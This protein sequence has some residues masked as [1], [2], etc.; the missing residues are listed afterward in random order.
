MP[1]AMNDGSFNFAI[2]LGATCAKMACCHSGTVEIV[3]NRE[4]AN[5]TPCA[6]WL[7]P[8]ENLVVGRVAKEALSTDASNVKLSFISDL[9]SDAEYEFPRSARRMKSEEL[10]AELLKS[11]RL[12]AEQFAGREI[13]SVVITVPPNAGVAACE[14]TKRAASNAGFTNCV[15]LQEPVAAAIGHGA[16]AE[17]PNRSL[18]IYDFG[19]TRFDASI[20]RIRDGAFQVAAHR[21][22]RFLGGADL[23]RAVVK[24]NF[25]PA[26]QAAH[27]AMDIS[28][29][30]PKAH[31]VFVKLQAEAEAAKIR[32]DQATETSVSISHLGEDNRGASF[33]FR[34]D[35]TCAHLEILAAPFVERSIEVC[36]EVLAEAH[37][38]VSE[39]SSMI[40]V[41]GMAAMPFV[42]QK[43]Q[44]SFGAVANQLPSLVDPATAVARGAAIFGASQIVLNESHAF[45]KLTEFKQLLTCPSDD[46]TRKV[47]PHESLE[48][49][50]EHSQTSRAESFPEDDWEMI[51][52]A[53][54]PDSPARSTALNKLIS[55]YYP[56]VIRCLKSEKHSPEE[57][58]D[59]AQGFFL[60]FVESDAIRKVHPARGSF[61]N[62]LRAV[63]RSYVTDIDRK[64]VV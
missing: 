3:L 15:L 17:A 63:L 10:T 62:F 2:D 7:N 44:E 50:S 57:V 32:L 34:C 14:A 20:L 39:V 60:Y 47:I 29:D 38:S 19:G 61:R 23:D 22:D 16:T 41:G 43:L 28:V 35:L 25:I 49:C 54:Q 51:V 37:L 6:V 56:F 52:A 53:Q 31:G 9:G 33:D 13:R 59:L 27:P 1:I 40:P 48:S 58:Q 36:T 64:S 8:H 18:L 42:R 5:Q 11:M 55:T 12:D 26:L 24:A 45:E 46:R 21:G 4:G 30:S